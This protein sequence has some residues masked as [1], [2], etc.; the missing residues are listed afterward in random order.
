M[1]LGDVNNN[2]NGNNKRD[3][4][5][6]KISLY[7]DRAALG[8][9]YCLDNILKLKMT[10]KNENGYGYDDKNSIA[11]YFSV[12]GAYKLLKALQMLKRDIEKGEVNNYG[13][14]NFAKTASIHFSYK[15]E[16][17]N[18][19][20]ICAVI[21]KWDKDGNIYDRYEFTPD[22]EG[23]YIIKNFTPNNVQDF[24]YVYV[25]SEPLDLICIHLDEFIKA[26]TNAQAY[27]VHHAVG[28]YFYKKPYNKDQQQQLQKPQQNNSIFGN[29][30]GNQ[31]S[32]QFTNGSVEDLFDEFD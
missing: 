10:P 22:I 8:F 6:S 32:S 25:D 7:N 16:P 2:T 23:N 26:S 5:Y 29:K 20:S 19:F 3:I 15:K 30:N 31:Q 11:F 4:V 21:Y 9:E 27:S 18:R 17:N 1:A 13:I 24:E 28:E 14:C 12:D